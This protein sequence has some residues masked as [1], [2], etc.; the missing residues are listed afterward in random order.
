MVLAEF[1]ACS[2]TL[3]VPGVHGHHHRQGAVEALTVLIPYCEMAKAMEVY[4]GRSNN[5]KR[6]TSDDIL[7]S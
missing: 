2:L 6:C 1:C 5:L 7:S 3:M 4:K